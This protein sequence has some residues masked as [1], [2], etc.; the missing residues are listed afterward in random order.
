MEP[1]FIFAIACFLLLAGLL[2]V[3]YRKYNVHR[4]LNL[5]KN[6]PI[7]SDDAIR[8]AKAIGQ[9]LSERAKVCGLYFLS[10]DKDTGVSWQ[11]LWDMRGGKD[12]HIINFIRMA[13]YLGCEVIVR[14]TGT[15]D[16]EDSEMTPEKFA[17]II[18]RLKEI[19]K[20]NC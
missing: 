2:V 8:S 14:Q 10:A 9:F 20:K 11:A 1:R 19:E 15:K 12:Y 3:R 13:R 4:A 5:P 7:Y 16:T 17:E 18:S 6:P